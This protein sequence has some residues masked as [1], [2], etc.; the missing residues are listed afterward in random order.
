MLETAKDPAF[1]LGG[2]NT[3]L[4]IGG[5]IHINNRLDTIDENLKQIN[6]TMTNLV[7]RMNELERKDGVND[8]KITEIHAMERVLNRTIGNI[9]DE[10]SDII[11]TLDESGIEMQRSE[12]TRRSGGN[13]KSQNNY[14]GRPDPRNKPKPRNIPRSVKEQVIPDIQDEENI[15]DDEDQDLLDSYKDDDS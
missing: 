10:V 4:I 7:S 5:G 8:E 11:D 13:K 9:Q 1:I 12:Y 3:I 2:V 6:A 14:R 15:Y